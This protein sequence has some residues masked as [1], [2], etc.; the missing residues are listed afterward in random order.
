[1]SVIVFAFAA[2]PTEGDD[3]GGGGPKSVT[4]KGYSGSKTYTLKI[5]ENTGKAAYQPV[6]GDKYTLTIAE[7]G[8]NN[9]VSSGTVIDVQP[10]TLF[11][12]SVGKTMELQPNGLPGGSQ[13]PSFSVNIVNSGGILDIDGDIAL[14][15]G[16]TEEE[17]GRV[18]PVAGELEPQSF[19]FIAEELEFEEGYEEAD[20]D[21]YAEI[22]GEAGDEWE[23]ILEPYSNTSAGRNIWMPKAGD[24]YSLTLTRSNGD[25]V[26]YSGKIISYDGE[27]LIIETSP[28]KHATIENRGGSFSSFKGAWINPKNFKEFKVKVKLTPKKDEPPVGPGDGTFPPSLAGTWSSSSYGAGFVDL[29]LG[30]E[31]SGSYWFWDEFISFGFSVSGNMINVTD[32]SYYVTSTTTY[33]DG[34]AVYMIENDGV[35]DHLYFSSRVRAGGLFW[36][37]YIRREK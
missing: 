35:V 10:I 12:G 28:G 20:K 9:K 17:P 11:D 7:T 8:Q 27:F 29:I 34:S 24:N 19:V 2:C 18:N 33:T 32:T 16:E 26:P 37:E 15:D 22:V 6:N 3:G 5:T 31:G 30:A 25:K 1:M 14:D 23:L 13:P 36:G 4:Y 21:D